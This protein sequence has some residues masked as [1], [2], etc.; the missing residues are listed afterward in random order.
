MVAL[1]VVHASNSRLRELGPG[2][3]ALFVGGTSGIG[4]FTLK[5]FV[6]NT[7]S[8]KVYIVGRSAP[9]AERIIEE[10]KAINKD[11]NVEFL[12]A[13]VTELSE[14][15][16]VCKEIEKKESKIN[17]IVQTQ[18][19]LTLAGRLESPEGIDRKFTLNFYSRMRFIENLRP[20]LRTATITAPH[21]S[22]T[23]SV[24]SA[25]HGE[26]KLDFDDLELKNNYSGVR[27]ATH[28]ITMNSIMIEEFAGRDPG[29]TFAHSY[30]SGVNT[31]ITRELPVWARA[32]FALF[33]PLL[34]PF[35]VSVEETGARQ[36]FIATSGI[37]APLKPAGLLASGVPAP[38]G[39]EI[40]DGVDGKV[41]SGAY[42]VNWNDDIATSK[43]LKEYR[44][45]GVGKTVWEH[46]MG[47]F[48]RVEKV[49]KLRA[50]AYSK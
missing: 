3:V 2:L 48:E 31:G 8:P 26:G 36:L 18:G 32:G 43:I 24:L 11:G 42:I 17:L 20:L 23:L 50:E 28:T 29:T 45:K 14:V 15:D 27:C 49:N 9:A 34:L 6:Q 19:N 30:P 25:G 13:N 33:K 22:R 40:M 38:K 21:F 4:E 7:I 44:E 37:Y 35:L 10:C 46:T 1:D 16:R 12:Q 41:G 47:I 5:A 39:M